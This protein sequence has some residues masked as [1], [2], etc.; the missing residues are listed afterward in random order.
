MFNNREIAIAI[1]F[2]VLLLVA[3]FQPTIRYSALK[4]ILDVLRAFS[5]PKT[6]I[7]LG[8]IILYVSG[9]VAVLYVANFWDTSLLKDTIFWFCFTGVVLAFRYY[10]S[11]S[12]ESVFTRIVVDNIKIIIIIQFLINF[13]TFS[14]VVELML[15]PVIAFLAL[16]AL[17]D[18]LPDA[19][20]MHSVIS[21]IAVLLQ[22]VIVMVILSFAIFKVASDY[23]TF[24]SID[25][26]RKILLASV[27]SISFSPFIFLS[28]VIR[29]YDQLF[30]RLKMGPEKDGALKRY[31]KRRIILHCGLSRF[32]TQEFLSAHA[33]D[34]MR[35][36]SRNDVDRL[37]AFDKNQQ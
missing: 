20:G 37:L 18:E 13:Y 1:W 10:T 31:A 32:R 9:I 25:I 6:L 3:S 22:I 5:R 12:Q 21:M 30:V 4:V 16:I 2:L 36:Q 15:M 8:F 26:F 14:L 19:D 23:E 34:L 29:N 33:M 28:L 35:I 11:T 24:V 27:L 17:A 7:W